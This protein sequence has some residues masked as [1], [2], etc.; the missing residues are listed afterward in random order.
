MQL[1][2]V[3]R[4][5]PFERANGIMTPNAAPGPVPPGVATDLPNQTS[6]PFQRAAAPPRTQIGQSSGPQIQTAAQQSVPFTLTG[7]GYWIWLDNT[8][9][10][11]TAG[12]AATVALAEDAP[13]AAIGLVTND[14]GGPQNINIDGYGLYLIQ[15][16]G[17]SGVVKD[18]SLSGD[19]N[20]YSAL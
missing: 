6:I 13:W 14:D 3:Q 11:V 4:P 19:A 10:L 8:V 16:Y 17:G 5:R 15:T 9:S 1:F 20:V 12:N 7:S 2:D 18:Q